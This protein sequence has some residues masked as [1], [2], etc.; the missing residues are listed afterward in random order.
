MSVQCIC[1]SVQLGPSF[2]ISLLLHPERHNVL[3]T[4]KSCD[5]FSS[6]SCHCLSCTE[7]HREAAANQGQSQPFQG[8]AKV[9]LSPD[10]PRLT[11]DF[12][13]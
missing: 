3:Q 13:V 4:F 5:N 7:V 6:I 9:E 10:K 1:R 2:Q 11:A 12:R 8:E